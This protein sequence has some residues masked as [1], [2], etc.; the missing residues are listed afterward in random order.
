MKRKEPT[1]EA[2][3]KAVRAM[4]NDVKH[5]AKN[6]HTQKDFLDTRQACIYLGCSRGNLSNLERNRGLSK[7]KIN[8]RVYYKTEDLKNLIQPASVQAS[9]PET[10]TLQHHKKVAA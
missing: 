7:H 9:Q 1:L 6:T 8:G 10:P 3:L 5:M 2:V 4:H